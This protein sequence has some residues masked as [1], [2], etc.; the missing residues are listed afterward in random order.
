MSDVRITCTQCE[1][2]C[3]DPGGG[4]VH[5]RADTGV[6]VCW[7]CAITGVTDRTWSTRKKR[8]DLPRVEVRRLEGTEL[9]AWLATRLTLPHQNPTG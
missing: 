9:L 3:I 7:A 6:P 4:L 2:E 8:G 1:A 5:I